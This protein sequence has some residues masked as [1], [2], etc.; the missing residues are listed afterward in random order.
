MARNFVAASSQYLSYAGNIITGLPFSAGFWAT[1]PVTGDT[2]QVVFGSE[3]GANTHH[4][5]YD[6]NN[7]TFPAATRRFRV[8]IQAGL[9]SAT[10]VANGADADWNFVV[11]THRGGFGVKHRLYLDG[12]ETANS[13]TTVTAVLTGGSTTVGR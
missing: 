13:S 8:R 5:K 6:S 11:S 1:K 12:V 3:N 9:A 10:L 4:L 2:Y 7:I